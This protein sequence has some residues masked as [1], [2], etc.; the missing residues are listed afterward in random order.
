MTLMLRDG[1]SNTRPV[2]WVNCQLFDYKYVLSLI[3]GLPPC[4]LTHA[5]L[6]LRRDR[7][8]SGPLTLCMWPNGP[9]NPIGASLVVRLAA[10]PLPTVLMVWVGRNVRGESRREES[11]HR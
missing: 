9:A 5:A 10:L 6:A 3:D 1:R 4:A 2:G 11:H 7:M 8:L